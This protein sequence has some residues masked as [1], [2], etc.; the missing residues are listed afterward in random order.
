[1]NPTEGYTIRRFEC[2]TKRVVQ[3]LSLKDN[4]E[5]IAEYRRLH[6]KEYIWK[7]VLEGI[8]AVGILEME[9]YI[10]GN[11]LVMVLEIPT[12][13]N[14]DKSMSKL[15]TLPRQAEWEDVVA[16]FQQALPGQSSSEKWQV[17]ERIFHLY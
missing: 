9:I 16:K 5:L 6:S 14:W 7:E 3:T 10:C 12:D 17:M 4:P 8:R 1:M 13:F 15:A 11:R 2:P